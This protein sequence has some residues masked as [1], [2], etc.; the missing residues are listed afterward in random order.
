MSISSWKRRI[1]CFMQ[2]GESR[3]E[4]RLTVVCLAAGAIAW[5][6]LDRNGRLLLQVDYYCQHGQWTKALDS[7]ARFP[8][9]EV[10][11]YAHRNI[12]LA[13]CRTGRLLDEMFY[14]PQVIGAPYYHL[15]VEGGNRLV[16]VQDS[17]IFLEL[18]QVNLAEKCCLEAMVLSGE[19]PS[20]LKQLAVINIA[21]DRP[22]TARVFLNRLR[23]TLLHRK[24]AEAMLDRL[25]QNPRMEDDPAVARLR[26][27]M[28]RTDLASIRVDREEL[29]VGLLK[30][31]PDNRVAFDL[32]NALYL[33]NLQVDKVVENLSSLER[34][35]YSRIPRHLQEAIL[36]QA[37]QTGG[38]LAVPM[39]RVAPETFQRATLFSSIFSRFPSRQEAARAS[40]EA[41]LGDSY[42]H[43]YA[44]GE[45]GL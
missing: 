28:A 36:V 29:L 21:K 1:S 45:A 13:L 5:S 25:K 23:K 16:Y 35:G 2:A 39:E 43:Y 37:A 44:F 14:Y 41:G 20:L 6:T 19:R 26:L 7:A 11:T 9:G 10:R 4:T 42:F 18:G 22:E 31:K 34:C 27:F 3:F 15:L 30:E 32:L 12:L 24:E 40:A 8:A 17:R 33:R 38:S